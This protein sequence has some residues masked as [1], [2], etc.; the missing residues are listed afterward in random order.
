MLEENVKTHVDV[1]QILRA[2]LLTSCSNS[3]KREMGGRELEKERDNEGGEDGMGCGRLE[4][5][6]QICL[7]MKLS[8]SSTSSILV[9][10]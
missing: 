6:R 10:N 3:L 5:M 9:N 8:S 1:F 2:C 4:A 7:L